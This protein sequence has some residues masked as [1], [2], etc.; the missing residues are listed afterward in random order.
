MKASPLLPQI[1]AIF[2]HVHDI[3]QARDWYCRLLGIPADQEIL[4]DHLYCIP[5]QNGPTL[6]LDS[7]IFPQ[8]TP[9]DAPL[10][11]FNTEDIEAAYQF[12]KESDVELV[13]TIQ[14]DHWF[15]IRDLD[16]NML[17]VC[18]C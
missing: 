4:F 9:D 7:K 8:H 6:I 13:G 10:F 12:L 15:N 17:M 3:E 11:H 5:M 1:G 18:K 16:G 14:N 2:V